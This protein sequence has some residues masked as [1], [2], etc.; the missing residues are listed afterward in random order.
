MSYHFLNYLNLNYSYS[1][2][3]F[4]LSM[5]IPF[6]VISIQSLLCTLWSYM[7]G[8]ILLDNRCSI[9]K[10]IDEKVDENFQISGTVEKLMLE[11]IALALNLLKISAV[12]SSRTNWENRWKYLRQSNPTHK[13]CLNFSLLKPYKIKYECRLF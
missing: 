10:L 2:F 5:N 4:C 7:F 8:V 3:N 12:A 11:S 1:M 13:I 6:L 9:G